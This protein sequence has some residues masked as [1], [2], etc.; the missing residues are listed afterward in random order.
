MNCWHNQTMILIC[1][2][3]APNCWQN[4]IWRRADSSLSNIGLLKRS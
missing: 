1:N 4:I 2:K 3:V